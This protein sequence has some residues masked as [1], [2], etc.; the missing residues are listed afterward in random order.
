MD[1]WMDRTSRVSMYSYYCDCR[2]SLKSALSIKN[3][4]MMLSAILHAYLHQ[5]SIPSCHHNGISLGV[6]VAHQ[7]ANLTGIVTLDKETV[8]CNYEQ[9]AP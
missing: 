7:S 1:G 2:C 4:H 5:S 6:D 9:K 8:Q 3:T